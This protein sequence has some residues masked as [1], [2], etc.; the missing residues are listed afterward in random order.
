MRVT[1][2]E[3]GAVVRAEDG[4][5]VLY[6]L[7]DGEYRR[8]AG[9]RSN[10]RRAGDGWELVTP[11]QIVYGFDSLGRL[12]SILNPR[13]VGL[14]FAYTETAVT[15]TDAS[16]RTTTVKV[17]GGLIR[18]I[19]LPD[20]RKASY[21]YTAGLLTKVK[22]ARGKVWKYRYTAAGL[23]SQVVN[24]DEKVE[25][26]NEYD[27]NGRVTRQTDALGKSTTFAWDAAKQEAT[28]TDADGVVVWDGYRGNVLVYSQRGNG[29]TN[30]HRYDG[31]LNRNLVVNGSQNQHESHYD[32]AGNLIEQFA[33]QGLNF[34]EKTK[35]DDRNNPTEHVDGNGRKWTDTYNEFDELV[36]SEDPEHHTIKYAYDGR[37]LLV[38]VTDQRGKV[39]RY[40]NIPDGQQNAGLTAAIVSPLGRRTEYGYDKT[41]RQITK[42][43]PRGTLPGAKP[44]NFTTRTAYDEQDRTVATT[45]P[46]K[47][48]PWRSEYDDVGRIKRTTTPGGITAQ[49]SYLDNSLLAATATPR[50]TTKYTYTAAGRRSTVRIDMSHSPDLVT[51]W[52]YNA[53][54]LVQSVTS[55]RGNVPGANPADFTTTYVYDANDNP[56]QI[57]RPYPGGQVVTRD[58]RVDELD[59]TVEK[60]DEFNRRSTFERDNTG[61]VKSTTDNLGRKT[62]MD[63]DANGRQTGLTDNGGSST[64]FEYDEAGNRTK[65]IS[66]TGGVSTF[67]YDDDGLPVS[68]TE[69][70]GNVAGADRERFTA[71]REY[72]AAGNLVRSIDALDHV[73]TNT[74]DANN[75]LVAVTDALGRTTH[76]TFDSDDRTKTVTT[77]DVRFDDD[78]PQEDATVYDYASDGVLAS[79]TDPKGHRTRF[80]YDEAGRM[81][82]TTDQLGRRTEA[83]YDAEGNRVTTI[84]LDD[85][86]DNDDVSAKERAKRTIVDTYDIVGRREKST[87]GTDG[88]VYTWGYDAKDRATSYGDPTGVRNV[89]YDDEDQIQSVT[90]KEAD[91]T[92]E[93]FTY[94]Y[95]NRGNVTT[96]QYPDGTKVTADYD[97]DSRLTALTA[98]D[99]T[100]TF[101][102]DVAGRRTST[103]LPAA[104][105]LAEKRA[106]DDAGRLVNVGTERVAPPAAETAPQDPVSN[107]ALTL[108]DVGNP[109]RVVTTR[110]G[111]AESVAYSYDKAD[112]L[113]SACYAV[114]S[115]G[116]KAKPAGRIDYS[117]DLVGNR[118]KQVRSGTAGDDVTE[119]KYDDADQLVNEELKSRNH[120]RD[121]EYAYD[122]NGNQIKAGG[123]RFS[124]NLDRS[125]AKATVAG[126]TSTFQYDATGLRIAATATATGQPTTTQRWSWD[127]A[128]TL[129]QIADDTV[130]D[131]A[132]T[133]LEQRSFAY[134]PDDEPLALLDPT[135]GAHS[136]THDWLGGVA[137]MLTAAGAVEK[138][139]DYDP[140]GNPRVGETLTPG[141]PQGPALKNPMQFT[142]AYQDSSTGDGNYFLRARNYNPGTGRFTTQDPMPTGDSAV[143]A[144]SYASNNP[145]AYTDPTGRMLDPGPTTAPA[146]PA[147]VDPGPSP[148][149]LAKAQQLQS[150]S[151]LDV[152]LEAG[153]Q[154][155][156]EFLGIND[157]INC[158]KGDLIACVSMVVGALPWGKIFKA[159]KI[160]EAIYRAGK[161]VITFFQE[162]KWA[163][164]IIRGAEKAAEAAKA[165]AAAAAKAAAEKA[166]AAKAAAE[167]AAKKVAEEAA[168]RAKALAAKAKAATKKGSTEGRDLPAGCP[169]SFV[170][171]TA[172]LLADGSTK[173]I[174]EVEP[175]DTV[176]T[177]DP[178]TGVTEQRQVTNTIRTDDDKEF[179]ELTVTGRDGKHTI[180]TTEHHPFWSPERRR[181]VDAGD[182]RT[183]EMLRTSAGTY[184]Q[185]GAVRGYRGE[186]RTYDLTVDKV[187]TYYVL[188][189]ATPVLVHNCEFSD[190]AREIWNAEPDQWIKDNVST[191]A[192]VRART[193]HGVV[194]VVAGSGDGLTPAQMGVP[195]RRGEMHADNIPGTDAEQNAFLFINAQPGWSPVAGGTSRNVCR[196]VCLPWIRSSGGRMMGNVYPG[197]GIA[198]T[199]QRS[200][201]W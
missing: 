171:G 165:A 130:T 177:T 129:P 85:D 83:G 144:Y 78:D 46:G 75:R 35:Y 38:T 36:Q 98:N 170:A 72:D 21:E 106:Y 126:R 169:H 34:S 180:T 123:D 89:V 135:T 156:M 25:P 70:R 101:G 191:V 178:I 182:L 158:L 142:G 116:D 184:V 192:V 122:L 131:A 172:V 146:D 105:G 112:R 27:A 167:A 200:F 115:C 133:V 79:V 150:K 14:R 80:D 56:I 37:G 110:G 163:R 111:V 59:R 99:A 148:E 154:I 107:F 58:I 127:V 31:T 168:A 3:G 44:Q 166:A 30:N 66:A 108:D 162:L 113:S 197:N 140:F 194:D 132:G 96:R 181:W 93:V 97:A 161:A 195:L 33:P 134:G 145:I 2:S 12:T 103:T 74:Y 153:G 157:I 185:I 138:G 10:L 39:T 82:R 32:A 196:A 4:A 119:Y 81:I 187:H 84:T 87:L 65:A 199:R 152:I 57:R 55:P 68:T 15:V 121:T 42:V 149:D 23:L 63:Y 24:P 190:R 183:G 43:D 45:D 102:Y 5:E 51:S 174:D 88:P 100:W 193:P 47:R 67:S 52:A 159:K 128:G 143:S 92:D 28:T 18:S 188:A 13:K 29:D 73:T 22:D 49:Y 60:T 155:L 160:A 104:T 189:G 19:A 6:T 124:Y 173:A 136:Y 62:S 176:V 91:R 198:T 71:H 94:G 16:G 9:V 125:L 117:Y 86:E 109:T 50:T 26:T 141:T 40:E 8:P 1:E 201:E 151:T 76:Y 69:P 77:P 120:E 90:R 118:T 53:K 17:E 11:H 48:D 147:T 61:Q 41:G 164:A 64:K 95:D 139:Y 137:N 7:S 186:A 54:G 20:G 175:G 179:V 114:E